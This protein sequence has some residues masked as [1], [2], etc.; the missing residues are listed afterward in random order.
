MIIVW[1]RTYKCS[2][3][4]CLGVVRLYNVIYVYSIYTHCK[5]TVARLIFVFYFLFIF[6]VGI[7][8]RIEYSPNGNVIPIGDEA[9]LETCDETCSQKDVSTQIHLKTKHIGK[10]CDRD[11]YSIQSQRKLCGRYGGGVRLEEGGVRGV[12]D[13]DQGGERERGEV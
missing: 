7:S 11:T 10:G 9:H 8:D 12:C 5:F 2:P 1:Q 6:I 3:Y 4:I 13:A